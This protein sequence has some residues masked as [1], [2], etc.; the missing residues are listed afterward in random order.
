MEISFLKSEIL[1]ISVVCH[2]L[3]FTSV[4]LK[5]DGFICYVT[6]GGREG[7]ENKD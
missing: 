2:P 1:N 4:F 6:P 3:S 5:D 7:C